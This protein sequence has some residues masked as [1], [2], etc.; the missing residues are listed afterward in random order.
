MTVLEAS[1]PNAAQITYWNEVVGPTWAAMHD[2]LD[3]E[4]G[5]LGLRA[6]E[7]LAPRP[8]ERLIDIG[9]GCG[10]TT[11]ELARRVGPAGLVTGADISAPMLDVAR[12]RAADAGLGQ[13]RFL[14]VD[15][16][17]HGFDA[18]DGAFSRFGVMFFADPVAAF[19]NI[20]RALKQGGRLAFV[21]WQSLENNPWMTVPLAAITPLLPGAAPPP[22]TPGAPGPFAFADGE[23]LRG[24]LAAAGFTE[25]EVSSNREQIGW[26]DLETSVNTALR[27]GP[28]GVAARENPD[29]R[30]QI[31]DAVRAAFA[32]HQTSEGVR[33]ESGSWIVRAA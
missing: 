20:R 13:T 15:A 30:P 26:G 21:C 3:G 18:A 27:V 28:V 19:A 6:I 24:L 22:I 23:R 4:L 16:Q 1:G 5:V 31:R 8:D 17:T 2:A 32:A 9:C 12:R 33:L 10:A 25:I 11:L 29:L 7:R 14:Q